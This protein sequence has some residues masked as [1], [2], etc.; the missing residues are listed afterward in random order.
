[1]FPND[2]GGPRILWLLDTMPCGFFGVAS[3]K[4]QCWGSFWVVLN[5][6][7]N[8]TFHCVSA[9][10]LP[11]PKVRVFRLRNLIQK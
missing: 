4:L 11:K 9:L 7:T 8:A 2:Q 6:L 5:I 1:M 3:Q 10:Q